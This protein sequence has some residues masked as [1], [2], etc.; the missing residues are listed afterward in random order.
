MTEPSEWASDVAALLGDADATPGETVRVALMHVHLSEEEDAHLM[1]RKCVL[2]VSTLVSTSASM[3]A[4]AERALKEDAGLLPS[5]AQ[6][7][8]AVI[9]IHR[10]ASEVTVAIHCVGMRGYAGRRV[11]LSGL[12]DADPWFASA[13]KVMLSVKAFHFERVQRFF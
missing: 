3:W 11:E 8:D 6:F 4:A 5:P 2:M 7:A 9:G 12:A 10:T 13:V 1:G